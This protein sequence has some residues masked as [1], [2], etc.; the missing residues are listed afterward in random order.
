VWA[1][2]VFIV[3]IRKTISLKNPHKEIDKE[4]DAYIES[5][6]SR[7][8]SG[9]KPLGCGVAALVLIAIAIAIAS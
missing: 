7:A 6:N 8:P 9:L 4:I 3:A 1:T 5:I 2:A